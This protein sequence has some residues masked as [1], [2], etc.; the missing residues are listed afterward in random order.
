MCPVTEIHIGPL[1]PESW[2]QSFEI[3]RIVFGDT[4]SPEVAAAEHSVLS[5]DRV[6]VATEVG[7]GGRLVGSTGSYAFDLTVPG[8][9]TVPVAGVTNVG[10][11][12]THRRRGI[13]RQLMQ[14]QHDDLSAAGTPIAILN[15]SDARIYGRIGY[16]MASRYALVRVRSGASF[17]GD[18]PGRNLSLWRSADVHGVLAGLYEAA[19]LVR[20]GT[21]TRSEAWWQML[22]GPTENWKA[23]GHHEV[24][25]VE[26][27][28]DD[29]GGYALYRAKHLSEDPF[30]EKIRLEVREVV[31]ATSDTH[32]ALWRYLLD[33]DLVD[34]VEATVPVDDPLL[35]R[36]GDPRA[37]GPRGTG[38]YLFARILD[39][40]AALS[41]RRYRCDL[42][43]TIGVVDPFRPDGA[44][45][46]TFRLEAGGDGAACE[47]TDANPD[48]V[49]GVDVLGSLYLG[50]VDAAV[51][52]DAGRI[53]ER[54]RGSV[55][56][57]A[58]AFGS[59]R[60][61]FCATHF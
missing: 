8:G 25:V 30:G 17:V 41:R 49:M 16:G 35:W 47:R 12:P 50:G 48:V 18:V 43:V 33:V 29:P 31:A 28:G 14:R 44:A 19:R 10:V 58:L 55:E 23:G 21:V 36:L 57:L 40:P 15:A 37:L 52:A 54:R 7:P 60:A 34:V 39:V 4:V 27:E 22:L 46:G 24:V 32:A 42:D 61:P 59:A 5:D 13:F 51:L 1:N 2:D 56:A 9:V 11:L 26:P 6:I 3:G 38:D 20:P 53:D 45:A